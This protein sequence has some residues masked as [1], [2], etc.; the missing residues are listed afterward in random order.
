MDT[1]SK[2]KTAKTN[3]RASAS[4]RP[5]LGARYGKIGISAVAAA[6]RFQREAKDAKNAPPAPALPRFAAEDDVA[7]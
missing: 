2:N 1:P 4:E 3:A 6:L 7:A 5:D